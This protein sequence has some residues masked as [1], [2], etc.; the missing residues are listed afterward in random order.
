[1]TRKTQSTHTES[2]PVLLQARLADRQPQE[3]NAFQKLLGPLAA[4]VPGLKQTVE[5]YV[6][7]TTVF[8]AVLDCVA[9]YLVSLVLAKA[10]LD[11]PGSLVR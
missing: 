10:F 1:M 8:R 11:Q 2:T 4:L 7:S 3:G 9:V 6:V 5:P